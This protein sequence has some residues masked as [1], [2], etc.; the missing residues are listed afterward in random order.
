M[1]FLLWVKIITPVWYIYIYIYIYIYQIKPGKQKIEWFFFLYC[2][3][4]VEISYQRVRQLFMEKWVAIN[5]IYQYEEVIIDF[6]NN[7]RCAVKLW[8]F[9]GS[10]FN[11]NSPKWWH[12][13]PKD[14]RSI[15]LWHY[16]ILPRNS[17]MMS[18]SSSSFNT[19]SHIN[20]HAFFQC[21]YPCNPSQYIDDTW[22]CV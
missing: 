4:F 11:Y 15:S 9:T 5:W 19:S 18:A 21:Q 20:L 2:I 10:H 6:E 13:Y 8:S 22:I 17:N 12:L 14:Q 16:N 3:Y 1:A 7:D